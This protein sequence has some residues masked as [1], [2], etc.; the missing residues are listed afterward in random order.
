MKK[1]LLICFLFLT[2]TALGFYTFNLSHT[3]KHPTF[4]ALKYDQKTNFQDGDVIFQ[5]STSGQ[6][7]AVQLATKSP[8][9]HVGLIYIINGDMYVYEAVQPVKITPFKEWIKHGDGNHYVVKRLKNA[10]EVLTPQVI[11]KMKTQGEKYLNKNYDLYFEWSD[12][13]IYCSEL[14]WKMYQE[15]TGIEL[16]E[17]QR[18]KDFDLTHPAVKQKLKERYGNNIPY[19]EKVISP[20]AIFDSKELELV[21]SN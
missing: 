14:I 19:E 1:S 12:E 18:L 8:Y 5:S 11:N 2:L 9:S 4:K 21:L 6:S 13:R 15:T 3:A 16:G 7:L 20:A 10:E 17:L